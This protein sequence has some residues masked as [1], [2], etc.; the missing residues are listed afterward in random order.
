MLG[1]LRDSSS[2]YVGLKQSRRALEENKVAKAYIA[3]DADAAIT[4]AFVKDCEL[5]G[6]EV[7]GVDTMA[8]L[9]KAA[10]IDIGA[11]VVVILK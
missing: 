1:E 10:G 4:R 7:I 2:I 11:A 5:A 6:V 3:G 8:E 9:G